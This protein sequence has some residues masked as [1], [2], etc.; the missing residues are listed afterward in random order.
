MIE[1]FLYKTPPMKRLAFAVFMV[2][3]CFSFSQS[4][5]AILAFP[6][7][8]GYGK[9]TV[10]GRGGTVY[11]VTNVNN[12]GSGSLR[13]CAEASGPRVCVFRI[14]GEIVL[15]STINITSPYI[16][17]AGQTA[18]GGGITLRNGNTLSSPIYIRASEVIIRYIRV[19]PGP[20]VA[21]SDLNDAI[22]VAGNNIKNIMLDHLSLSWGTDETL[23]PSALKITVQWSLIYE[24][25]KNSTHPQSNHSKA[26]FASGSA[27]ESLSMHHNLIAH[28]VDR[29]PNLDIVGNID[30][31]NNVIYNAG[32]KFGEFY[33]QAGSPSMNY[34]GNMAIIGPSSIKNT[35]LYAMNPFVPSNP[36]TRFLRLFVED[37]IDIHR[38]TNTGAENLVV[39]PEDHY[40]VEPTIRHLLQNVATGPEQGARDVLDFAGALVPYRDDADERIVNEVRTCSGS[41]ISN[42]SE[43]GGWPTL[44]SGTA[45]T[46]TDH[47]GMSDTWENSNG[48]NPNSSADGANDQDSDGYTNLEEYINNLAGDHIARIGTGTGTLPS[49]SCGYT[50]SGLNASNPTPILNLE[51][52]LSN[53]Y[54]GEQVIVSWASAYATTCTASSATGSAASWNGSK[55]LYGYQVFNPTEAQTFALSCTG[56]GGTTNA[57]KPVGMRT[58]WNGINLPPTV[59][60][61][62]T[63]TEIDEGDSVTL[64]WSSTGATTCNG[65]GALSGSKPTT[66]SAIVTPTSTSIYKITCQNSYGLGNTG[67][68]VE[69][70]V[71]GVTVDTTPPTISSISADPTTSGA[72][73][74]WNTNENADSQVEYGLT[75]S[76]GSSTTLNATLTSSHSENITGLAPNTLY[77]Y[78]VVS[79]D[80]SA[81][82]A[83]SSD[84]TFTTDPTPGDT[85][86]PVISAVNATPTAS[87]ATITW[88]TDEIA[89]S[90]VEYGLTTL[91]PTLETTHSAPISGLAASTLYHYRVISADGST[92]STT[93][94]DQTFTTTAAPDTTPP[95]ITN[96]SAGTPGQTT[97]TIVWDTNEPADSQIEYGLTTSYGSS[98]TLDSD[99]VTDHSQDISGL[100]ASTLYHY[101]VISADG[102]A[103][104]TTSS[105]QT[106]TTATTP[107]TTPPTVTEVTS[108]TTPGNDTTPNYTFNTTEAG[109]ITYGGS[110]SSATTSAVSGNNTITFNTLTAGTYSNCTLQV[111]DGSSN[112]SS[113]LAVSSFTIDTTAPVR[114][115]GSPSGTLTAGTTGVLLALTTNETATCKFSTTLGTNYSS[116][117]TTFTTTG[118]T[119]HSHSI[120]GLSDGTSYQYHVRCRDTVSNTNTND[121]T[122]SFSI[123]T[124]ADTISPTLLEVTPITSPTTDT[125]PSY[126]FS[127][128]EAGTISYGGACS[129]GTTS[130]VSGNNTITLNALSP[131]LYDDCTIIVTDSSS[132]ASA[133][134]A[135]TDFTVEAGSTPPPTDTDLEINK[136]KLSWLGK[137]TELIRNASTRTVGRQFAIY[138]NDPELADGTIEV[139][140]NGKKIGDE[141]IASDGKWRTKI[142]FKKSGTHTLTLIYTKD[143]FVES[144][145][146]RLRVDAED[147]SFGSFPDRVFKRANARVFWEATD[148]DKVKSYQYTFMNKKV[149][150][151]K[152]EFFLPNNIAPGVYPLVI[153]TKDRAGNSTKIVRTVQVR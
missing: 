133:A 6:T 124:P 93:S 17:I 62:A 83:T 149:K 7:A 101:R 126:T 136:A 147:P 40:L 84:Q 127:S 97:A 69:V 130:A 68:V 35:S 41:I 9:N 142:S 14:S 134:L 78:R 26:I 12:S 53:A 105:D 32:E 108:V 65:Y 75:T 141:T 20:T 148:N 1:I 114:S 18:P 129:S 45:P 89:D 140:I 8:E 139:K 144:K 135:I 77:H 138:G 55:A 38:P 118:S 43:V 23:N 4:A 70:R 146:Y 50:I 98:T 33:D 107:D 34:V 67:V 117:G 74:T 112:Q 59:S 46:D 113:A 153:K 102:S 115:G 11:E 10:G 103:N 37:N 15:D 82:E 91:D 152:P 22:T 49:P 13:A 104:S 39:S 66:G 88:N 132:N 109:V 16:T 30:F 47:D 86:P 125:T 150:T 63:S 143:T 57:S 96:I 80:S 58:V 5:S 111:R 64:N 122:L 90:Q 151:Q 119:S 19:R 81:N 44:P 52:T 87:S 137:T 95:S 73:I 145:K 31:V 94:S 72:T 99:L 128:D 2:L 27:S 36:T 3:G 120:S 56:P 48:L 85:T 21:T 76:Y 79:S 54:P 110:C 100:T 29:N 106:F 71:D 116:M 24:G 42:P 60:I 131:D 92:N 123:D 61:S 121:Y 28:F 51:R 25:L